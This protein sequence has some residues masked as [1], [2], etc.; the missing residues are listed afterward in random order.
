MVL[1]R[2]AV[3][4]DTAWEIATFGGFEFLFLAELLLGMLCN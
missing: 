1:E 2:I 4:R 3:K